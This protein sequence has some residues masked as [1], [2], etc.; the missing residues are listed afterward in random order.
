MIT[1]GYSPKELVKSTIISIPKDK[2]ASLSKSTN[3]RGI[4]LFNSINKLFDYI[5]I[6]LCGDTLS[7]NDMQFGY[8]PNHSTT[9]CT[10][11]LKE[12]IKYYLRGN[13]NVYCCL[14]DASKAFDKIYFGKFFKTL[15]SKNLPPLII[16]LM[17]N[18]YIRQETRVSWGIH[19]SSYFRLVNGVK[20][21]RV[22]S[23]QL[24]TLYIDKLLLDLKQ[25]GYGCHIGDTFTGVLSYADDIT[26]ICPSLR[27]LNGMLQICAKFAETLSLTFN[28][29]K[30]MCIKFGDNVNVNESIKLNGSQIP[31]VKKIKHL[32]NYVNKTLSD[33]S[34][35]QY[36][37]SS[38]IGS[39][40]TLIV[41]FGNLQQNVIARL[42][43]S[44]CCSFYGSQAW[45]IDSTDYKRI[46]VTWNKSVRKILKLPYTTHT[47]AKFRC[48]V[49]PLKIETGRYGVNRVPAEERLCDACN[50]VEDEFHVLMK[51]PLYR[52]ARGIC[53]NS[54]SAVSDVFADLPQESQFIE[55]M[56]N[57]LY[58]KIISKFMY[59]ILNQRRYLLYL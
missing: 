4:S 9:S 19:M 51:C 12:I 29:K 41:N 40:N 26:L 36:K 22:I 13:S 56:S 47:Y 7:T 27:G 49:A 5:I 8:K 30:S 33:K 21:G 24:F 34:D 42:F 53:L 55:L 32:G 54:I 3:Y 45:Q 58:Y 44:Y 43:K 6:D 11:V 23:A 14:L 18:S 37:L 35:C 17:L 46:C 38:F 25:S 10:T 31:W 2:S 52:D 20:Q 48:G 1:H 50:S 28:C 16:R 59:T 15:I 57:P 39:V